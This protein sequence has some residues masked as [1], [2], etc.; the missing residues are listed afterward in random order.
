M[1][2]EWDSTRYS[3]QQNEQLKTILSGLGFKGGKAV[4]MS[5][6]GK[7]PQDEYLFTSI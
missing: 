3:D 4:V 1:E 7:I 6:K 5:E 2:I